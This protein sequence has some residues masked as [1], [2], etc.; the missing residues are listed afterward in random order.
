MNEENQKLTLGEVKQEDLKFS[1]PDVIQDDL[2]EYYNNTDIPTIMEDFRRDGTEPDVA[3]RLLKKR[4]FDPDE[5]QG[6]MTTHYEEKRKEFLKQQEE[7]RKRQEESQ[8]R[9][10]EMSA[11]TD[12]AVPEGQ[13]QMLDVATEDDYGQPVSIARP[14]IAKVYQSEG[15]LGDPFSPTSLP[16]DLVDAMNRGEDPTLRYQSYQNDRDVYDTYAQHGLATELHKA[17]QN[18]DVDSY[19]SIA[20]ELSDYG[21]FVQEVDNLDQDDYSDVQRNL[22][23]GIEQRKNEVIDERN[24]INAQFGLPSGFNPESDVDFLYAMR[25]SLERQHADFESSDY[26]VYMDEVETAASAMLERSDTLDSIIFGKDS[27]LDDF[28]GKAIEGVIQSLT[29][30]FM[31]PLVQSATVG[32]PSMYYDGLGA[33]DSALEQLGVNSISDNK[34]RGG[35]SKMHAKMQSAKK[36]N[37]A[38]AME[39]SMRLMQRGLS[40]EEASLGVSELLVR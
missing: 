10:D 38:I 1:Q 35:Q 15:V 8:R 6:Q 32:L 39:R 11:N 17:I 40:E 21:L 9:I 31:M 2:T 16:K 20:G 7:A 23:D 5:V 25:E 27:V 36:L 37:D 24:K 18:K 19:N 30:K 33:L 29:K 12:L 4:G 13:E 28:G 26:S 14:E 3:M 22:F 34:V